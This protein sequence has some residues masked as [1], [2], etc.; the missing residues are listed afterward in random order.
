MKR[1]NSQWNL[2]S[3]T[4][5]QMDDGLGVE[6]QLTHLITGVKLKVEFF[7]ALND[8]SV[9]RMKINELQSE[10]A[11]F[12][13]KDAL[14]DDI[15]YSKIDILTADANQIE[16]GFGQ[17]NNRHKAVINASPFRIDILK[18]DDLLISEEEHEEPSPPSP[19][20]W[21]ET[22]KSFTDSKPF[23]PM[24]VGMDINFIEF[25]HV[26]GIPEHADSFSLKNTNDG[27]DPYRLYNLDVFEYELQSRMALYGAIPFILAH[28]ARASVGVLWLNPSETWIDIE[29]SSEGVAGY[30]AKLVSGDSKSRFT[31]WFSETGVIDVW[32][33]M[34]PKPSD[35]VAQNAKI[36]GVMQM[37][38]YYS[39]GYHQ[40]R[41]NYFSDKEVMEVD[42][43]FDEHDIPLDAIWLD[44]EYTADRSKKY[45]TWDSRSFSDPKTLTSNLTSMG[46]RLITI[47]DPHLKRD[48]D[49]A[50]YNEAV[51]E[52][53]LIKTKEGND[54]DGWC[55]PGASVYPDYINPVVR[56]WWSA[57]FNPEFF[58]GFEGGLVDYWNDMN[59][60][61]V[62]NGPE[63]TAAK[64]LRHFNNWEHRDVHNIYGF[65][66]TKATYQGLMTHRPNLRPFILTRSFFAGSQRYVAM[67]TGDNQAKWDHL[68]MVVPMLLSL[69][70]AGYTFAGADVP[71]FFFN[72]PSEELV[73]RWYQAAAFQLFFRAH[74]HIDTNRREPWLFSEQ[75]K[76]E[77]RSAIRVRY[78]YLPYIY[79]LVYEHTLNGL[80]PLRPL[81]FEFPQD[82]NTFDIDDTFLL[83]DALL[84]H[85]V[86]AEGVTSVKIYFPEKETDIWYNAE[87]NKV[88]NGG[89]HAI[90]SVT[91]SNIPFF[92]RGGTI[93]AKRN[94]FRRSAALTLNDPFTFDIVLEPR[95]R[96]AY[97]R[98]YL[99][100]GY[101]FD[102]KSGSYIYANITFERKDKIH[103]L[104]RV[105]TSQLKVG[106][107]EL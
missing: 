11:R 99:D 67:W 21:E 33:M 82:I 68:K 42:R 28:S 6:A 103:T 5:R 54:Y 18:G 38:P 78:A 15:K 95:K 46:R 107:K 35:V 8:G 24:S 70:S 4:V 29:S 44:V 89:S 43:G 32:F 34:G 105:A 75:T 40:S 19:G 30:L 100:D 97:G 39:L 25:D 104:I 98:I 76:K 55:W 51:K 106:S 61:S 59:E 58:P 41:W 60:P 52:N 10:R 66:M 23:G 47:I 77:I 84:I 3:Q 36:T 22:F 57:K 74:A 93:I 56:E 92:Q 45:F 64:D 80:P 72:P 81:W 65:Y 37:P 31:H 71:G 16:L 101:T 48:T 7:S 87:S 12:E 9:L 96:S 91:T 62:F 86:T 69:A 14:V 73:T 85:P 90:V 94:R 83:G 79:T 27:G 102:Y 49:Y 26:Y 13:A 50:V 53:Y 20:L 17:Q 88:Y 63:I 2:E 1:G